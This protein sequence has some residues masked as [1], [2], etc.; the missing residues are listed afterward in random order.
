VA[1]AVDEELKKIMAENP[2]VNMTTIFSTE[3]HTERTYHSS[4]NALI[5]GSILAVVVVWCSCAAGA[6]P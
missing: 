6:R 1:K 2:G 5:E 4:I 3:P